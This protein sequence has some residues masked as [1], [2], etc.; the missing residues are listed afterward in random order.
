M[1]LP[2]GLI[3][4]TSVVKAEDWETKVLRAFLEDDR[5][6]AMPSSRK[7]RLVILKWLVRKFDCDRDYPEKEL[8]TIIQQHHSDSATL[9]QEFI[10]YNLMTRANTIYH[11][12]PKTSWE[13][14]EFN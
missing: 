13:S 7:K 5:I 6:T 3:G 14:T 11:R 9:H 4:F 12:Q 8:N 1:T 2:I 10:G